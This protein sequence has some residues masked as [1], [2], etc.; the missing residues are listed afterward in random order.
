M[1]VGLGLGGEGD[2]WRRGGGRWARVFA[3]LLEVSVNYACG[4]QKSL[5]NI[6]RSRKAS[7]RSFT[8]SR[9]IPGYTE[10]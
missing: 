1:G 4:R 6:D 10:K 2:L 5:E 3:V 8:L 7:L 9:T